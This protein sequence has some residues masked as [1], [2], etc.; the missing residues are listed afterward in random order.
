MNTSNETIARNQKNI[1]SLF[2]VSARP[3]SFRVLPNEGAVS[4][5][6][7]VKFLKVTSVVVAIALVTLAEP[8]KQKWAGSWN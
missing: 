1:V 2:C 3:V 5:G 4:L 7:Y 6:A 8:V